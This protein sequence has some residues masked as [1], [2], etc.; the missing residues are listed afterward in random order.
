MLDAIW[1]VCGVGFILIIGFIIFVIAIGIRTVNQRQK[2]LI[3]RFGK[4]K[5][6]ANPGL[7]WIVPVID[8]MRKVDI[9]ENMVDVDPQK[10]ITKDHKSHFIIF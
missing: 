6:T 7:H 2:G 4:Y 3:E 8:N 9:T 10:I 1:D 5:K